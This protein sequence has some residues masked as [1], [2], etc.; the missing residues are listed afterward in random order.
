MTRKRLY[1]YECSK[2]GRWNGVATLTAQR[3]AK[4]RGTCGPCTTEPT[5]DPQWPVRYVM[6]VLQLHMADIAAR[7]AKVPVEQR[8]IYIRL[9]RKRQR[10][11][12]AAQEQ[13]EAAVPV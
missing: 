5:E 1:V 13:L 7:G 11:W 10:Q 3:I 9:Y 8:E 12:R 6:K 2:C 4:L